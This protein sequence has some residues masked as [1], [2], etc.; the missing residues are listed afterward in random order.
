MLCILIFVALIGICTYLNQKKHINAIKRNGI[1][2]TGVIIE[3]EEWDANSERRLGGNFN[4][5]V[6][7]FTTPDGR[8]IT[9]KPVVGFTTQYEVTVPHTVTIVYNAKN[10][11]QFY[12]DFR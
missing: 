11:K 9:G 1:K 3:N 4:E 7:R 12:I 6:V 8:V 5:P 10:P 2:T